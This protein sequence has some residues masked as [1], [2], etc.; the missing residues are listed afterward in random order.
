MDPT[1][2]SQR[3]FIIRRVPFTIRSLSPCI[4]A[5]KKKRE[6]KK[7]NTKR[8]EEEVE[9]EEDKKN[10]GSLQRLSLIPLPSLNERP[11]IRSENGTAYC[12]E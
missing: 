10:A 1:V 7:K 11:G 9:G 5:K 12:E 6:K 8:E 2:F 3:V 4:S